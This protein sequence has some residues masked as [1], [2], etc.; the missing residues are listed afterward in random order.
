MEN[1]RQL[2]WGVFLKSLVQKPKLKKSLALHS[3][4]D[5][6]ATYPLESG[7]DLRIIQKLLGHNSIETTMLYR[8]VSRKTLLE[9]KSPLD[10]L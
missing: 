3:R 7:T 2:V 4:R 9:V 6:Y 1:T 10:F 8:E 5:A